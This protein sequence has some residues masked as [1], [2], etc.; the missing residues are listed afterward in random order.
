MNCDFCNFPLKKEK[1][2]CM[3]CTS[4]SCAECSLKCSNCTN[5]CCNSCIEDQIGTVQNNIQKNKKRTIISV[6]YYCYNCK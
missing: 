3:N 4:I 2:Y 1:I 6:Y 5:Y